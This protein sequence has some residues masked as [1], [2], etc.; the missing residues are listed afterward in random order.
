M[1]EAFILVSDRIWL[2][3]LGQFLS[4]II[5]KNDALGEVCPYDLGQV[6]LCQ[7]GKFFFSLLFLVKVH[8]PYN[9]R[10]LGQNLLQ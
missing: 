10:T 5:D 7:K 4:Q 8:K 9:S 3:A 2:I 6:Y 1:R